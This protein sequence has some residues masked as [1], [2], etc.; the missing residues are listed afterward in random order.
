[1]PLATRCSYG[2]KEAFCKEHPFAKTEA[3]ML[4]L[5]GAYAK[6]PRIYHST[7]SKIIMEYI[8]DNCTVDETKA[9]RILAHLHTRSASFYGLQFDT[10][11]GPFFQP[12]TPSD[13]WV[14]FFATQRVLHM[15]NEARKE[16]S[17]S[18]SLFRDLQKLCEKLPT[19]LPDRP[20]SSLLHGDIWSGNLLCRDGEIYLIDPAL[21]YGHNEME[22]AFIMMFDTFGERFFDAYEE[23]IP[24][25]REFFEYR[26]AIYQIYPY[27]VHLR[28]YGRSYLD[29]LERI[30]RRFV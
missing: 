8:A 6:T 25:E 26:H 24:I 2:G 13:S 17:L 15:A 30:V 4:S 20:K 28:I 21:Y 29:A 5:L 18:D 3:R 11:I 1:M 19:L 22:L 9:A 14:E 16:A 12:N 7:D 27:L 23:I 10:T